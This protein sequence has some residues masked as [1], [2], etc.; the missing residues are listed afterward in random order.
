MDGWRH[1][2]E[3]S[4]RLGYIRPIPMKILPL[5]E[6]KTKLSE[7]VSEVVATDE[8]IT[9]TRNG[10]A[11]VVLVSHDE[12]ESWQETAAILA[13][14]ELRREIDRGRRALRAGR[15]RTFRRARTSI[16][17]SAPAGAMRDV[18]VR[19]PAPVQQTIRALHPDLKRRVRVAID[20]LRAVPESGKSL[21]GE[22]EGWRSVR[23]ARFRIIYR[24]VSSRIEIAAIGP[25]PSIYL[26]TARLLRRASRGVRS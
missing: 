18:A 1:L 6:A 24:I 7:L 10:R 16:D 15:G 19:L 13:D 23:V 26:E 4:S 12:F 9:I 21:R 14:P 17:C 8:A 20:R 11:T 2:P 25:R 3:R 22:L 5:A